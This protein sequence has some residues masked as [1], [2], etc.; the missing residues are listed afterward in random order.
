MYKCEN[1][2][3]IYSSIESLK[4]HI[5]NNHPTMRIKDYISPN[6]NFINEISYPENYFCKIEDK[7]DL[8]ISIEN[9]D[10]EENICYEQELTD[11]LENG[12]NEINLSQNQEKKVINLFENYSNLLKNH[13]IQFSEPNW[14][15]LRNFINRVENKFKKLNIN[16]PQLYILDDFGK[17]TVSKLRLL[18]LLK[19]YLNDNIMKSIVE[20]REKISNNKR[21][22]RFYCIYDGSLIQS[23]EFFKTFPDAL[24]LGIYL[25]EVEISGSMRLLIYVFVCDL[26]PVLR[27]DP[28]HYLL[29]A[30]CDHITVKEY[31]FDSILSII[32]PEIM[33]LGN[34][35]GIKVISNN[36]EITIRARLF[37]ITGDNEMLNKICGYTSAFHK[38]SVCCRRCLQK[39]N[40]YEKCKLMERSKLQHVEYLRINIPNL[41]SLTGLKRDS[42]L[43]YLSD[44][45]PIKQV[46]PDIAHDVM[47]GEIPRQIFATLSSLILEKIINLDQ[48]NNLWIEFTKQLKISEFLSMSSNISEM[49]L[50][51]KNNKNNYRNTFKFYESYL[52]LITFPIILKLLVKNDDV[53]KHP[54]VHRIL[55]YKTF[56]HLLLRREH[57]LDTLKKLD[58]IYE[59]ILELNQRCGIKSVLK[60]HNPI[61][62]TSYI[63]EIG[64]LRAFM[65]LSGENANQ[66]VKNSTFGTKGVC[67]S[68]LLNFIMKFKPF[69]G[70]DE[71]KIPQYSIIDT[72]LYKEFEPKIG[73]PKCKSYSHFWL[74]GIKIEKGTCVKMCNGDFI[75]VE[76]IFGTLETNTMYVSGKKCKDVSVDNVLLYYRYSSLGELILYNVNAIEQVIFCFKYENQV[77][78][79]IHFDRFLLRNSNL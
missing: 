56:V 65:T 54:H 73:S 71:I 48:Y 24:K 60:T 77:Y 43:N 36:K 19:I 78:M 22:D 38:V 4:K 76:D 58:E 72:S 49:Q 44:F 40:T 64:S 21:K 5:R 52:R 29:Y 74:F 50:F 75:I 14:N 68:L 37:I 46:V 51:L 63:K 59:I 41:T 12:L 62:Y 39:V 69:F 28:T 10:F 66:L 70:T 7:D 33:E 23:N 61:H 8:N 79:I 18:D 20:F 57:S 35:D 16:L 26:D 31:G 1:C 34:R 2:K 45:D 25:D 11:F 42:Y 3:K 6:C 47:G 13:K 53:F 15:Y 9:C 17:Y 27:S 67:Y 55:C 30:A 32:L